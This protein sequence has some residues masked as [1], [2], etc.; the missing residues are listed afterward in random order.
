MIKNLLKGNG[1]VRLGNIYSSDE[2]VLSQHVD[3][4]EQRRLM[5]AGANAQSHLSLRCSHTQSMDIDEYSSPTSR[6]V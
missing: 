1:S 3:I 2:N 6:P 4:D 5:G